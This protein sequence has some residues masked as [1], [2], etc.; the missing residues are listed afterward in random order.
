M[1]VTITLDGKDLGEIQDISY[2]FAIKAMHMGV[3]GATTGDAMGTETE[4]AVRH[5]TIEAI[6]ENNTASETNASIITHFKGKMESMQSNDPMTLS[7]AD[8]S[9][10]WPGED[11]SVMMTSFQPTYGPGVN[12]ITMSITLYE[13]A[14]W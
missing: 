7:V 5:I 6:R 2:P 1:T 12:E 10:N 14:G 11:I 8:T 3:L 4:G 13:V 9:S